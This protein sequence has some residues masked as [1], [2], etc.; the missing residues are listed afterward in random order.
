MILLTGSEG[1]IGRNFVKALESEGKKLLL[2]DKHNCFNPFAH[3]FVWENIEMVIHQ[4]AISNTTCQDLN[5]L[6]TYN[7]EYSIMLFEKAIQYGIPVKYASSASVYGDNDYQIVNPL[8]QY[9]LSKLQIDYWVRENIHKF[10]FI[11]GFRYFNV[12]GNGEENKGDQA[13]PVSKFTKQ[14]KETG[15]LKIFEGSDKI[16][17]DFVCV[18]DLVEIVLNNNKSS[19]IYDLGTSNP[20]SFEYVAECIVAKYGGKVEKIPFP[21]H[22]FG[23]YQNYTC[24]KNIW[25]NYQF[26]TIKEYLND[27]QD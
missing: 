11:Q 1:F 18:D 22:L 6:Y 21:P 25:N 14:I 23:K 26:K 19:G 17:R 16:F 9:A 5:L 20:V 27:R 12:Y 24:A 10:S 15:S 7:V 2:L 13:S 3:P 8:N 4:G